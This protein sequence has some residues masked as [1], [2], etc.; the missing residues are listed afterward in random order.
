MDIGARYTSKN[1]IFTRSLKKSSRNN[2]ID[3][4]ER[5]LSNG[6]VKI[7]RFYNY[8]YYEAMRLRIKNYF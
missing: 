6:N 1:I 2:E 7:Y 8:D 5:V 3:F 4:V